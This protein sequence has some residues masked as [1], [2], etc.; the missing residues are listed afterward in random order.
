VRT[1]LS[2]L[3]WN[4]PA[5]DRTAS[6]TSRF[7]FAS[8]AATL[9]GGQA[10]TVVW[11]RYGH[12]TDSPS[13]DVWLFS[14]TTSRASGDD[15]RGDCDAEDSGRTCAIGAGLPLLEWRQVNPV[16]LPPPLTLLAAGLLGLV[17]I[18]RIP[19]RKPE[20]SAPPSGA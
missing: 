5:A 20:G 13:S 16:P 12:P 10:E 18:R 19:L 9:P 1:F 4:A 11:L 8:L 3:E 15:R 2:F 7:A 6:G 17:L 14:L